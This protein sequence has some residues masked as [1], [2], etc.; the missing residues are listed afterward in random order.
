M[1]LRPL[2]LASLCLLPALLGPA[3]AQQGRAV[4]VVTELRVPGKRAVARVWNA[5]GPDGREVPHYSVSADGERFTAALA[6]DYELRLRYERFDPLAGEPAVPAELRA[7]PA[8][9]L[10]I[11][12]CRTQVL[13]DWRAALREAGAEIHFFLANHAEVVALEPSE[14]AAVRALPFVRSVTPFHPAFKLEE[15]LLTELAR[16]R[17]GEVTVNLLTTRRGEHAPVVRW[18]EARGGRIEHVSAETHF[19]TA[20]LARAALPGLAALDEVQWI[21][22]WSAPGNDMN[23]ARAVHGANFVEALHG[24][25]GQ[26]VRVEVMDAGFDTTHPDMTSFLVHNGNTPAGHG[27]C[28][29]GIVLGDGLARPNARGAAPDAFLVVADYDLAYSGGSRYAH[30]GQL[31]NPALPYKCVLQSN[32]WGGGLTTAYTATAQNMDL[33]LFD[34]ARISILQSQSN[35]GSQSSRP[36]AWAKNIIS[37][38]GIFHND[39]PGKADDSWS[40]GASIGPAADGRIKPDVASFFD[41]I[42]CADMVGALGYSSTNYYSS[43]GGTSGATPIV[44][45]HLALLYQMWHEGLFGN[46]TPGAT[47][48][49]NAPNN[50]TAKALLINSATPWSF[51]G[52]THDLTRTHQG[53]G[54]PDLERLSLASA[55]MLVV[56]EADVLAEL[57]S[58]SYTVEVLPGEASLRVTMVYRDPPGTTSST[59]HRINDL[60]LVV[61]SPSSKVYLGNVGLNVGNTSTAGGVANTVDTVENVFLDAPEVGLWT[62]TVTASDVNQDAHVETGAVD[63]DFALV[64]SGAEPPPTA[65]PAVPTHLEGRATNTQVQLSFVDNADDETGFEL[66]RSDD[67]LVFTPLASLA[68]NDTQ[69]TDPGLVPFSTHHYRVRALNSIGPSAWS[70]VAVVVTRKAVGAGPP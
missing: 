39:T 66:E 10:W 40:G 38:G 17:S 48:F 47:P 50:T 27:T 61:T 42:L 53:W 8:N 65:P 60:D 2:T 67:G 30:T 35:F 70:N 22:R 31:V 32:S 37:V 69:H 24:F 1:A 14:L 28:T 26:G 6:T 58:K 44:A 43:F 62:V 19:M 9:R 3:G 23:H 13:E 36:E 11:V 21:D 25:T 4:P 34:H 59:L 41:N 55:R 63:V 16:G 15:E 57:A 12:Q 5:R 54:H 51:T 46:P 29:S 7:S 18:V 49:E 20:T 52:T 68:A 33:I 56:D 64:V 45:G